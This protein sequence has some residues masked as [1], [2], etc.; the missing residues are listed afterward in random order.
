MLAVVEQEQGRLRLERVD[1]RVGDRTTVLL[2][3]DYRG[4]DHTRHEQRVGYRS[5]LD[6]PDSVRIPVDDL[7]G[8]LEREACLAASAG[9]GQRQQAG[10]LEKSPE[11]DELCF[12]TDEAR[13]LH[14]EVVRAR[15]ERA[16]RRKFRLEVD[17]CELEDALR[18]CEVLQPMTAEGP[19]A[20]CP[21][22]SRYR[23]ARV[24]LPKARFVRR[25]R[26]PVALRTYI[27]LGSGTHT[28]FSR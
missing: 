15:V 6:Q 16:E 13:E 21:A 11:L 19:L 8:E 20:R 27:D 18:C 24:S 2:A 3:N 7:R 1:Q 14:R 9:A 17:M 28:Y 23:A 25:A 12:S 10:A 4:G 22:A 26:L 5:Q